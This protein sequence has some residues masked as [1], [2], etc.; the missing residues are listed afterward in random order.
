MKDERVKNGDITKEEIE[1]MQEEAEEKS[2]ENVYHTNMGREVYGGGGITPDIEIEQSLLTD[3]GVE[4]RR[5][6]VFFNYSVD[7][8]IEHE[9]NVTLDYKA[10]RKDIE[11]LLEFAKAEEIEFEQVEADS[12]IGWIENELTSNIIGRKFGEV[13]R[14]KRVLEEDTQLQKTLEIFEKYHTLEEMYEYAEETKKITGFDPGG[15]CPF[16]VTEA[17]IYVDR[18]LEQYDT[19]YPAAGTDCSGV[20]MTFEQ[21]CQVSGNPPCDVTV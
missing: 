15:V 18:S 5:K 20:P 3:L 19:V 4:L 12:I 14:Y 16:G 8:L 6:S 1:E 10:S 2:H 11:S 9:E 17:D 13:E 21:L 7:Y